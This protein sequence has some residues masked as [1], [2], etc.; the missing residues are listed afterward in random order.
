MHYLP[1]EK[2]SV[3][4]YLGYKRRQE[5]TEEISQLIDE[6]M[7]EVQEVSKA[8]YTYQIFDI[9]A[10]YQK[11]V[12]EILGTDFVIPGKNAFNHLKNADKVALFAA[13]L[14][15]EIER[16]TQ[17]YERIDLTKGL[18]LDSCAVEYVET[19]IELAEVDIKKQMPEYTLNRRYSPGYG[20]VPLSIQGDFLRVCGADRKLGIT[21]TNTNLMIPRKS[22]TAFVGLF[23]DEALAL[24]KRQDDNLL[25]NDMVSHAK[26]RL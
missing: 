15:I 26:M 5:L 20:D 4:R 7:L 19:V 25:T 8:R 22:V 18:I 17:I 24:P 6:L 13:T 2:S 16:K 23:K 3:L 21:L 9:H 14:G 10:N 12:I 1:L 11:N